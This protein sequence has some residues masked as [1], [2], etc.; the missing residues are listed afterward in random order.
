[1]SVGKDL[2]TWLL[3][4]IETIGDRVHQDNVPQLQR[5][6]NGDCDVTDIETFVYISRTG[7]DRDRCLGDLGER[8]DN[9]TFTVEVIGPSLD[10]VKGIIDLLHTQDGYTGQFGDA[11]VWN[12][13]YVEDQDDDYE[14]VNQ[15]EEFGLS[16]VALEIEVIH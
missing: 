15:V 1:M 3:S 8:P 12:G 2:R 11:K 9:E 14:L 16:V 7:I 6:S 10:E 4:I 5:L 13:V